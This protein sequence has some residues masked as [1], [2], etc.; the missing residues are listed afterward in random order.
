MW[1]N[2]FN[3]ECL[4]SSPRTPV[5]KTYPRQYRAGLSV[6]LALVSAGCNSTTPANTT[7]A[8]SSNHQAVVHSDGSIHLA[9]Y[10]VPTLKGW[11]RETPRKTTDPAQNVRFTRTVAGTKLLTEFV[12]MPP[13]PNSLPDTAADLL[14]SAQDIDRRNKEVDPQRGETRQTVLSQATEHQGHP[15]YMTHE[16]LRNRTHV[17]ELKMLRVADGRN[18]FVF[19]QSSAGVG[20]QISPPVR[21][22]AAQ[23][24]QTLTNNAK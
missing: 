21:A 15:A 20:R 11:K 9:G 7:S 19:F 10:R 4:L 5:G 2:V 8:S 18:T 23:A 24:W 6:V 1:M 12:L 3:N 17:T 13:R 22:V 16:L 14:K